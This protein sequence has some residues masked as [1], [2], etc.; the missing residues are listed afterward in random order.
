MCVH[1]RYRCVK[2]YRYLIAF[3]FTQYFITLI[4]REK[5]SLIR[6]N[7]GNVVPQ[8]ASLAFR[9]NVDLLFSGLK[10]LTYKIRATF[11]S[12]QIPIYLVF[13]ECTRNE[14]QIRQAISLLQRFLLCSSQ[15]SEYMPLIFINF[16]PF[17]T[18][19]KKKCTQKN[20]YS[21]SIYSSI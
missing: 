3:L 10:S 14:V 19:K 20:N 12:N 21:V 16:G 1:Y 15:A 7:K 5:Q 8:N 9:L 2:H 13:S 6:P 18:T 17:G 11:I 4:W